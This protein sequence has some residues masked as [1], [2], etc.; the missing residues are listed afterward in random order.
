MSV[1]EY[2]WYIILIL[3]SPSLFSPLNRFIS[4]SWEIQEGIGSMLFLLFLD[5]VD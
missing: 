2:K 3:L 1:L 5:N 4:I